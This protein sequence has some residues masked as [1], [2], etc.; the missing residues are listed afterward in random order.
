MPIVIGDKTLRGRGI[1]RSVIAAL[2]ERGRGLGYDSLAVEEI[3]D[4][5]TPSRR[6]FESLGFK[7]AE[8]TEKGHSYKLMFC[9]S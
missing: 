2:V 3:Y 8:K 1:G 5:N 7:A 4:W 9:D 6:C